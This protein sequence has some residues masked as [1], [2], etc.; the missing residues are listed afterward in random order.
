MFEDCFVPIVQ[1]RGEMSGFWRT[2]INI[3][4][5]EGVCVECGGVYVLAFSTCFSSHRNYCSVQRP[6]PNPDWSTPC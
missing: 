3:V 1:V 5:T 6:V 2:F 4:R